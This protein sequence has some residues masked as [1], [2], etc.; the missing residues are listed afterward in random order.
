LTLT[1]STS[2]LS[3]TIFVST[4]ASQLTI[5]SGV[6]LSVLSTGILHFSN[7]ALLSNSGTL[8]LASGA[9][10]TVDGTSTALSNS[11]SIQSAGDIT[12]TQAATLTSSNK[13]STIGSSS[14]LRFNNV[15]TGSIAGTANIAGFLYVDGST[16][17]VNALTLTSTGTLHVI[18]NGQLTTTGV[19]NALAG[20]TLLV[21]QNSETPT[22]TAEKL[23][24][25][26]GFLFSGSARVTN[27]AQVVINTASK[28]TGLNLNSASGVEFF[29]DSASS[30]VVNEGTFRISNHA[31][32]NFHGILTSTSSNS[33]IK[34]DTNGDFENHGTVNLVGSSMIIS[35]PA[36]FNNFVS[37]G[38]SVNP[39]SGATV[40][41]TIVAN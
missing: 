15:A 11:G 19:A 23:I 29:V 21:G 10:L 1:S 34:V 36:V 39:S 6:T 8:T 33:V 24:V 32:F 25:Q 12:I 20:S 28:T 41:G 31:L 3:G 7:S 22:G 27:G 17:S 9:S 26:A 30:L 18:N 35:S 14:I 2:T 5:N 38:A 16:V 40:T 37:S 4:A 13:I